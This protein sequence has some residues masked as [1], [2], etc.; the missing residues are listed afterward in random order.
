MLGLAAAVCDVV[1]LFSTTA[2]EGFPPD[3]AS[4]EME[5]GD[6][7]LPGGV[8]VAETVAGDDVDVEDSLS[9]LCFL[10]DLSDDAE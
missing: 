6:V 2:A 5:D 1:V 9:S 8:F 4:T 3:P 7:T 10:L